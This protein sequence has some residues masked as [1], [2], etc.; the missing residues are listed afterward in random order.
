MFNN[1][2]SFL[3]IIPLLLIQ[4]F[5]YFVF[6]TIIIGV[7]YFYLAVKIPINK[8]LF[9]KNKYYSLHFFVSTGVFLFNLFPN[10][11]F[12]NEAILFFIFVPTLLF[13]KTE[14]NKVLLNYSLKAIAFCYILKF[15]PQNTNSLSIFQKIF[16]LADSKDVSILSYLNFLIKAI[17]STSLYLTIIK[18]IIVMS[19]E[20]LSKESEEMQ[21]K[22]IQELTQEK[23]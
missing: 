6:Y 13:F 7:K 19:L 4:F 15:F 22:I 17:V 11:S 8:I 5:A 18:S 1:F 14:V 9:L 21:N 12:Y 20:V 2:F 3:L 10:S 16:L 23:E